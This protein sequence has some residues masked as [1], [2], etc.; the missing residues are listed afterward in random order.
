MCNGA[1]ALA[2][3]NSSTQLSV[4]EPLGF[5]LSSLSPREL[6]IMHVDRAQPL[7]TFSCQKILWDAAMQFFEAPSNIFLTNDLVIDKSE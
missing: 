5:L 4:K 3:G 2:V 1:V 7:P 6:L